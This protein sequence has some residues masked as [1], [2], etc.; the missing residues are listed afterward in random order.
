MQLLSSREREHSEGFVGVL[1]PRAIVVVDCL[2]V[3]L[4]FSTDDTRVVRQ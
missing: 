4:L 1:D 2:V 3:S